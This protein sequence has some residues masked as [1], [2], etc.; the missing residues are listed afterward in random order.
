MEIGAPMASAYLLGNPD[1][2]TSHKFQTVFWKSYVSEVLQ[3]WEDDNPSED[4]ENISATLKN[5]VMVCKS[6]DGYTPYSTVMDYTHHALKYEDMNLYD[7]IRLSRKK[8]I[9]K[10]KPNKIKN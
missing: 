3:S 9:P 2:Y 10:P 5:K 1:H 8:P 4:T 7:W 6:K